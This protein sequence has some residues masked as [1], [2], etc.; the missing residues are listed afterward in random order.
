MTFIYKLFALLILFTTFTA[1]SIAT[2]FTWPNNKKAAISLGYD[3]ALHSHLDNAVPALNKHQLKATFYVV[4]NADAMRSRIDDWRE[5][6]KSGHELGNHTLNHACRKSKPNRD[7]IA[8]FNDLDTKS[9]QE[10][11]L[12]INNA[13]TFLTAI[14]GKMQRTFTLPC[15]DHMVENKSY[16]PMLKKLFPGIK[17]HVSDIP[18]S[19]ADFDTRNAGVFVPNG[20]SGEALIAIAK[21]ALKSGTIANYTFHGIGADHLSVT[22]E[23]HNQLLKYLA[24][25]QDK[26]WVDTF[27]NISS[28]INCTSS[29]QS[30]QC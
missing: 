23:A 24:D 21:A 3:D 18:T 26:Y 30:S 17:S 20:H 15:F 8:D 11:L 25:N 4:A 9:M 2:E 16:I 13:N 14:D 6:A 1:T 5:I 10:H 27:F 28:F 29:N 19:M 7:W 12:E 22:N